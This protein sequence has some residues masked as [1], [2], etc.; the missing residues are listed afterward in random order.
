MEVVRGR[1]R[2]RSA[3][4][5]EQAVLALTT[6]KASVDQFARQF[7][8]QPET[9]EGW[10]TEALQGMREAMWRRTGSSE[11]EADFQGG[12]QLLRET[13]T[14]SPVAQALRKRAFE[15]EHKGRATVSA[16]PCR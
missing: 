9:I 13:V 10:R 16:R 7:A 11:R 14:D 4:D 12:V 1:L 15:E 6:G 2:L 5:R 8:V 3:S